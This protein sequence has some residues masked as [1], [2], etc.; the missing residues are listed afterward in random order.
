MLNAPAILDRTG[1]S[2]TDS[3]LYRT[4]REI[5]VQLGPLFESVSST[6][7]VMNTQQADIALWQRLMQDSQQT[8]DLPVRHAALGSLD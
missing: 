6:P 1:L 7:L 4:Q 8:F 2:R 3:F 5:D